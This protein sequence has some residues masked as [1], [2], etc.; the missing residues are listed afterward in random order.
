MWDVVVVGAGPGGSLAAKKCAEYGFQTLLLERKKLP[1]DKVCSGMVAGAWAQDTITE[2]FGEIPKDALVRPFHLLGQTFH[3]PGAEPQS[4]EW[5]ILVAWRKDLD[6]W[7]SSKAQEEGV[8]L[9]DR[10]SLLGVEQV[11]GQCLVRVGK[12]G[13]RLALEARYVVGADGGGSAVR[14]SLFPELKI[15]YSLPVREFYAG[16]LDMN[17]QYFHWFFPKGRPRPRFDITFKDDSFLIEGSGIKELRQEI[18]EVLSAHGFDTSRKPSWKDACRIALLH[19]DLVT[20]NFSPAKGNA[21]LVGD[22]AGLLLPISFEGIGSAL[23]SGRVAAD[24]ILQASRSGQDA[25]DIYLA[26]LGPMIDE[27]ERL[28]G[29]EKTLATQTDM[30]PDGF[31]QALRNAYQET[32]AGQVSNAHLSG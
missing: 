9:W 19:S 28:H 17:P 5:E 11:N 31:C 15:K 27:I 14:K 26:S 22:A 6:S 4:F 12:D 29:I 30:S 2:E 8:E 25:A 13:E 18:S 20:R 23:K 1:R 10:S 3:V 21:L 7:M 32:L 16:P 24:S